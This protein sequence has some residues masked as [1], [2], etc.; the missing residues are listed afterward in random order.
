MDRKQVGAWARDALAHQREGFSADGTAEIVLRTEGVRSERDLMLAV[1]ACLPLDPEWSNG[2]PDQINWDSLIDRLSGGIY[3][4]DNPRVA[5]VWEGAESCLGHN[6]RLFDDFCYLLADLVE[7]VEVG[8]G[9]TLYV[10]IHLDE[11]SRFE[12]LPDAPPNDIENGSVS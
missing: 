8:G 10:L 3:L 1:Q 9:V 11:S 7:R 12:A 2:V 5:L 6:P 4:M